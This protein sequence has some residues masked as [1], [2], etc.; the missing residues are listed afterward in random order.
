MTV[1]GPS[2]SSLRSGVGSARA[3]PA[4]RACCPILASSGVIVSPIAVTVC[5][6]CAVAGRDQPAPRPP[7]RARSAW[8]PTGSPSAGRSRPRS[9]LRAPDSRSSTPVTSAL[10]A[11]TPR[12]R[13][14]RSRP[15][16]RASC[17][18]SMLMPD[19]DQ[20]HAEREALERRGD[21]LDLAVIFGLGD[22]Q[23]GDQRAD[24]RRQARRP[25]SPGWR[26]S[27]PAG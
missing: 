7:R 12:Q 15:V 19:G 8:F 26:R 1:P 18:R 24:D 27:P 13:Q 2:P 10:T 17:A 14:Q 9:P 22:Q 20:E 5:Q 4:A 6:N 21:H 25:R 11:S 3:R 23:P 16:G